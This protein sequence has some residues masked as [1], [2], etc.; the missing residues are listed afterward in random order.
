V[1]SPRVVAIKDM[2]TFISYLLGLDHQLLFLPFLLD[3]WF[4]AIVYFIP[5]QLHLDGRVQAAEKIGE[6]SEDLNNSK[7]K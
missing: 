5:Y 6:R 1:L 2:F 4:G 7:K 3:V